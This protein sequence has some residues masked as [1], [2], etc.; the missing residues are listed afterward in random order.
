MGISTQGG[1]MIE[2][3]EKIKNQVRTQDLHLESIK[4][5]ASNGCVFGE[6]ATQAYNLV[7]EGE[8]PEIVF[9]FNEVEV[10]MRRKL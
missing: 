1:K 10:R 2:K 9:V 3:K 6:A 8:V 7:F 5:W 4:M